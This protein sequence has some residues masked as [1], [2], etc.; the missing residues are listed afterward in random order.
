MNITESATTQRR[1]ALS[2]T[3]KGQKEKRARTCRQ[4]TAPTG[5]SGSIAAQR[6]GN[7]LHN[8]GK[9]G[10]GPAPKEGQAPLQ[11]PHIDA[12]LRYMPATPEGLSK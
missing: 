2:M 10:S 3:L 9:G 5:V 4:I 1:K 12:K 6:E 8:P 11:R 7:Q